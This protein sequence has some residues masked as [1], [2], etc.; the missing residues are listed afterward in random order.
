V[1]SRLLA[2]WVAEPSSSTLK[3]DAICSS[4]TSVETQWTTRRH[5][6]EDDTLSYKLFT[7]LLINLFHPKPHLSDKSSEQ[8]L[9]KFILGEHNYQQETEKQL[10]RQKIH[11]P[12]LR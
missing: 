1:A 7:F 12:S 5:I 11:Y 9:K 6:P 8:P 3:M 2:R 4:K 10:L